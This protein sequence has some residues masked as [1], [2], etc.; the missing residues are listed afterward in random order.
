MTAVDSQLSVPVEDPVEDVDRLAEI[1][2]LDLFSD[3]AQAKLDVFARRAAERFD[4]PIGLASIVLDSAQY[5]A[6]KHGLGGWLEETSGTP[7]E[8]SFCA[9]TVRTRQ[10]YVVPDA[11]VD[12]V[13]SS[14]PLVEN[15]GVAAYAGT[16][17]ITSRG[18]VLGSY[19]VIGTQARD[20]TAAELAELQEMANEVVAEIEQSRISTQ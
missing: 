15:D 4:L 14:N 10:Q 9:T 7:V 18:H 1:A 8:W 2:D 11:V 13:T 19:C 12:P 20:F 3:A 17:L 6:G 5:F 16:P